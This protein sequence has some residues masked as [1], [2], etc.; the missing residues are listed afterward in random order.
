MS[1]GDRFIEAS[2]RLSVDTKLPLAILFWL[3]VIVGAIAIALTD[4][5]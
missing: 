3:V 4:G 5:Q 2:K 1:I